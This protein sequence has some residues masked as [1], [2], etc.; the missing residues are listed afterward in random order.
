MFPKKSVPSL[1]EFLDD[2]CSLIRANRPLSDHTRVE[3]YEASHPVGDL[4]GKSILSMRFAHDGAKRGKLIK[5]LNGN[6]EA[7]SVSFQKDSLS[8]FVLG[9]IL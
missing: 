3:E 2:D 1:V 5:R 9:A 7:A 4:L 6:P 8:S